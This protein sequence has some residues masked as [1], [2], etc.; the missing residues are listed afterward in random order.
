MSKPNNSPKRFKES[1]KEKARQEMVKHN[2]D[3]LIAGW[4][5]PTPAQEIY[6]RNMKSQLR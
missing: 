5:T 2:L 6:I 4:G 3:K 1:A